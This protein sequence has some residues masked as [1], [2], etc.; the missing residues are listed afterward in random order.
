MQSSSTPIMDVP[1]PLS[2]NPRGRCAHPECGCEAFREPTAAPINPF[3]YCAC[4]H[5][6]NNH[7]L[8]PIEIAARALLD[9]MMDPERTLTEMVDYCNMCACTTAAVRAAAS[10]TP[11]DTGNQAPSARPGG[12][13]E[14]GMDLQPWPEHQRASADETGTQAAAAVSGTGISDPDAIIKAQR[15][16][17]IYYE[18]E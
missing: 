3:T 13:P 18:R 4:G 5:I 11:H 15:L 17:E 9:L 12:D 10:V 1:P 7:K 6:L 2:R 8:W 16:Y 14:V